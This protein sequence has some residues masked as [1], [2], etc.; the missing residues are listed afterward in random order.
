MKKCPDCNRE[1]DKYGIVCEYCGKLCEVDEHADHPKKEE[2]AKTEL[3][4]NNKPK[5]G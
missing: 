4:K 1:I 3:N 5:K 2:N